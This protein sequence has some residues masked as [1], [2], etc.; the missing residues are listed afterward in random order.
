MLHLPMAIA[1]SVCRIPAPQGQTHKRASR[2]ALACFFST[3][4]H[5]ALCKQSY[6][7]TSGQKPRAIK[8]AGGRQLSSAEIKSAIEAL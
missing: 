3:V 7:D 1:S 8:G 4:L 5:V 6:A 2:R